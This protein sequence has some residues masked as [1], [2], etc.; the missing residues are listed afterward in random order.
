M[1]VRELHCLTFG[2]QFWQL[3]PLMGLNYPLAQPPFAT[4]VPVVATQ[5][6]FVEVLEDLTRE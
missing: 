2:M 1:S 6:T 5:T 4:D 3:A